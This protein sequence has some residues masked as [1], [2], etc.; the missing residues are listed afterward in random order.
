MTRDEENTMT[1]VGHATQGKSILSLG[2]TYPIYYRKEVKD[3]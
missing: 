2:H 3:D 1:V